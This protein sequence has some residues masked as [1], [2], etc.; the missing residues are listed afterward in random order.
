MSKCVNNFSCH[1]VITDMPVRA[2]M[3]YVCTGEPVAL[4]TLFPFLSPR[5]LVALSP[6]R[7]VVLLPRPTY[8]H[9]HHLPPSWPLF[10]HPFPTT[11]S[12]RQSLH[13]CISHWHLHLPC[14][15]VQH[16]IECDEH[17]RNPTCAGKTFDDAALS[18]DRQHLEWGAVT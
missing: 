11:S 15:D 10:S 18:W 9:D 3:L 13:C 16:A 2:N 5:C 12:L 1:H 6:Y 17:G 14:F 7:L 8:L 4:L